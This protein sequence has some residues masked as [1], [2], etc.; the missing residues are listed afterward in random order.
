MHDGSFTSL[1]DVVNHYNEIPDN[2]QN[3]LLDGRLID[4]NEN[5]Q[6]LNLT[7]DQKQELVSFL[8]TLTGSDIY[9]NEKWS[10]PFNPDGSIKIIGGTLG[11][12]EESLTPFITISPNP[13]VDI[14]TLE[15]NLGHYKI[16]VY[17]ST[18]KLLFE[19]EANTQTIL[20][21]STIATR[22][23]FVKI[24]TEIIDFTKKL[25]NAGVGI[26]SILRL[27]NISKSDVQRIIEK[28]A[29][30]KIK[31][32]FTEQNQ[33]YE[34][35]EL[36][37]YV[38]NKGNQSWVI[39]AIN[40]STGKVINLVVGRRTKEN[41]RKVVNTILSLNPKRIYTD[42]LNTYR[43]LISKDIHRVRL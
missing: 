18:G 8:R 41:I 29:M 34:L 32:I 21:F 16:C 10:D 4:F 24:T 26:S 9:T 40:K 36:R 2:P 7:E 42:G 25:N 37:T 28:L 19:K 13:V 35:D 27:L 43:S 14:A 11:I 33:K 5:P 23:Y 6:R 31:P 12:S 1:L 17:N 15:T 22:L 30:H 39:Y 3:T 20:D 38:G